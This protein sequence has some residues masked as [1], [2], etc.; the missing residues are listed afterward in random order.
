MN[1]QLN[2]YFKKITICGLSAGILG[3]YQILEQLHS[4]S[5]AQ[6]NTSMMEFRWDSTS[7]YK[8]LYYWQSSRDKRDRSTYYFVIRPKDRRSGIL[9][10]KISFPDHFNA[11]LKPK[12][13]TLCQ[14]EL[15]SMLTKTRCKEKIPT[16]FEVAKDQSYVEAFPKTIIPA[17]DKTYAVVMKIFNPD[18]SGMFQINAVAQSPGD[19]PISTYIGSWTVDID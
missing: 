7:R 18:Q 4:P 17:D 11:T 8:K 2:S 12:K 9:K 10:L 3:S 13:F 16:V 14:A 15:G 5:Q 19:V 6:A 1:L